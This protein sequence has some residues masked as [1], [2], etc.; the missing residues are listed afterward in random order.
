M[1]INT[2]AL[3]SIIL[4]LISLLAEYCI[5]LVQASHVVRS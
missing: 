1:F 4:L 5:Q 3:N 2:A